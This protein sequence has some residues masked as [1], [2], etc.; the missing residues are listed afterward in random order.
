MFF[1]L[2]SASLSPP[3]FLY[4]SQVHKSKWYFSQEINNTKT[5]HSYQIIPIFIL[6]AYN[7]DEREFMNIKQTFEFLEVKRIKVEFQGS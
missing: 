1:L 6:N 7:N 5:K 2:L 3:Y 4:F